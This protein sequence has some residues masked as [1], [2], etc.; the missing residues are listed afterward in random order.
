MNRYHHHN[1][2]RIASLEW[3][4]TWVDLE[5]KVPRPHRCHPCPRMIVIRDRDRR[6]HHHRRLLFVAL[7]VVAISAKLF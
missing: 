4:R 5:M 2:D 6:H 7:V 3:V 1:E